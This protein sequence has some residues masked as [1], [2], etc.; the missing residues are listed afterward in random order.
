[1]HIYK[2]YYKKLLVNTKKQSSDSRFHKWNS[3]QKFIKNCSRKTMMDTV[4]QI[5]SNETENEGI[6]M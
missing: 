4:N 5:I 6:N 3:L 2:V 1:M